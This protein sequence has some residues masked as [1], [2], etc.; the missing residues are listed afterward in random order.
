ML[1]ECDYGVEP[2]KPPPFKFKTLVKN[3]KM[4]VG[5]RYFTLT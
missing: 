3:K 4:E 5:S 1:F 2:P